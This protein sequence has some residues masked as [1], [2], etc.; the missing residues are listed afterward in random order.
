[1]TVTVAILVQLNVKIF[2]KKDQNQSY[3]VVYT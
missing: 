2:A 3:K 1:M